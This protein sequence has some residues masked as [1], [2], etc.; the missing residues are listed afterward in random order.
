MRVLLCMCVY[1][2]VHVCVCM[3]VC[4]CVHACVYVQGKNRNRIEMLIYMVPYKHLAIMHVIWV[5][6]KVIQQLT[7]DEPNCFH[8]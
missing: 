6:S 2:R 7:N 8:D 1:A 5:K 4:V 3:C